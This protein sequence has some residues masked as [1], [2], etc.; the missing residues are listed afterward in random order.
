VIAYTYVSRTA[1][2]KKVHEISGKW[3]DLRPQVFA[4]GGAIGM[5]L[6]ALG[7]RMTREDALNLQKRAHG[8]GLPRDTYVQNY[9]E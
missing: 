8:I 2:E 1:A 9:S 3:P 7:G 4:P 5:Y 6:V